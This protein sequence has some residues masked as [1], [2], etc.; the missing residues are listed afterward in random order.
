MFGWVF[1]TQFRGWWVFF[2]LVKMFLPFLLV[3]DLN[4]LLI[5]KKQKLKV[6]VMVEISKKKNQH[7]TDQNTLEIIIN[8]YNLFA[9]TMKMIFS[10]HNI[11]FN[12]TKKIC[13]RYFKKKSTKRELA[14]KPKIRLIWKNMYVWKKICV[15]C[16]CRLLVQWQQH[17][18]K[19]KSTP[20]SKVHNFKIKS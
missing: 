7:T 2:S 19:N 14:I 6:V 18:H 12:S 8:S 16:G 17:K 1:S 10:W 4:Q 11:K 9:M 3:S 13:M 20:K 15:G 5:R